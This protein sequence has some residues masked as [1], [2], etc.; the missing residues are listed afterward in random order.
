MKATELGQHEKDDLLL[1]VTDDTA[2]KLPLES[3]VVYASP[4]LPQ[5]HT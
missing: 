3:R 4:R 5:E 2:C 1:F